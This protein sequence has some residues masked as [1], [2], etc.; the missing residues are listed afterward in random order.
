MPKVRPLRPEEPAQ[1]GGF[2]LLGSLGEGGQG[3]V[4]L[5]EGADGEQ[6]ALKILHARLIGDASARERFVREADATR[7]VAPFSTARVITVGVDED[8][9]Y[10]V[11][12]LVRGDSLQQVVTGSGPLREDALVRLAIGTIAALAGIHRA[13]IVHRDFKPSNVLLGP[14]GPRVI[15]FGIARALDGTSTLSSGVLGTPAYMSPEQISGDR[16]SPATDVFSWAVTMVFAATG[17]PA[18]GD[19][20]TYPVIMHRIL[21]T[22]PDLSAVPPPLRGL[23]TRC[24]SKEPAQRPS[25]TDLMLALVSDHGADAPALPGVALP[26]VDQGPPGP[27]RAP[28]AGPGPSAWSPATRHRRGPRR[29]AAAVVASRGAAR[30]AGSAGPHPDAPAV[31]RPA[32]EPYRARLSL[33][34]PARCGRDPHWSGPPGPA[35]PAAPWGGPPGHPVPA[36][37]TT[38][39]GGRR[40]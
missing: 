31:G 35:G 27:G 29:A 19:D 24:L 18:F 4:Y 6:V 7:R 25:A 34:R 32:R 10:I 14:D 1:L 9:P 20:A 28:A 23:L 37:P 17:R 8:R 40:R 16:L 36:R 21:R 2:K 33:G 13:G 38:P 5:A 3:S 39:G 26:G 12:E 15:D 22:E 30:L 11:S